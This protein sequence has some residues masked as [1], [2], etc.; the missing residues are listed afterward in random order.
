LVISAFIVQVHKNN[1]CGGVTS[2]FVTAR[3]SFLEDVT[4]LTQMDGALSSPVG[5]DMER[6]QPADYAQLVRG[7]GRSWGH[8]PSPSYD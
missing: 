5:E 4:K 1:K 6:Y 2:N 3:L 7:R 8:N